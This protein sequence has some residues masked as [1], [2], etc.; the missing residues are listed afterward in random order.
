MK[1]LA[2][3][4]DP[5]PI[6][7]EELVKAGIPIVEGCPVRGEVRTTLQGRSG[8]FTFRRAWYYWMVDGPVPLSVANVMYRVTPVSGT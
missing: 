6:V 8:Q 1:N 5:D 3:H 2:G 4:P 7:R